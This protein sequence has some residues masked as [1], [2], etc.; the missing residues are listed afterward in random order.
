MPLGAPG[1]IAEEVESQAGTFGYDEASRK[2]NLPPSTGRPDVTFYAS[3]STID[4][5]VENLSGRQTITNIPGVLDI[6]LED[7]QQD[8]TV[9]NALGFRLSEPLHVMA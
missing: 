4:T 9:N 7:D 2:F 5:G 8:L 1:S 3:R 6:D